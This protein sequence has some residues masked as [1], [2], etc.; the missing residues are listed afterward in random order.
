[1]EKEKMKNRILGSYFVFLSNFSVLIISI[2][3]IISP[4]F[5]VR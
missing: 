5:P 4:I 2:L 3:V 1:M